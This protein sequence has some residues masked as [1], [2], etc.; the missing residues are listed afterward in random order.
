MFRHVLG[1]EPHA[2][3]PRE[4]IVAIVGPTVQHYLT[5]DLGG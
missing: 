1:I 5:G 3:L 2:S 4:R